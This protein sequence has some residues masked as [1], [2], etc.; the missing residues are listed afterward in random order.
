MGRRLLEM[1]LAEAMTD[2]DEL[3][4][5]ARGGGLGAGGPDL[6]GGSARRSCGRIGD[7]ERLAARAA[8]GRIG[9]AGLRQLGA[10]LAAAGRPASAGA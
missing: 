10:A 5:L 6:A 3:Q 9:P 2:L 1:R 4:P 8:T 7:L